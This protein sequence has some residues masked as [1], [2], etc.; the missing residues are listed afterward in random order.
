MKRKAIVG[1]IAVVAVVA[2]AMF[3]GCVDEKEATTTTPTPK[4]VVA[5]PT[6]TPVLTYQDSEYADW[7][8]D[9]NHRISTDLEL[10]EHAT[11]RFDF[12]SIG[13]YSG[14]LYEDAKKGLDEID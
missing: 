5:T 13:V 1:L 7:S 12:E 9:T 10:L 4:A 2:V 8:T 14:M 3:A 6:P 11:N